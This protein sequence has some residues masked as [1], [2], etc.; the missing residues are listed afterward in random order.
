MLANSGNVV[1][2]VLMG[3]LVSRPLHMSIK[4]GDAKP[5]QLGNGDPVESCAPKN[6]ETQRLHGRAERHHIGT[7]CTTS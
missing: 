3:Q 4:H 2:V 1:S 6:M 7:N 5:V